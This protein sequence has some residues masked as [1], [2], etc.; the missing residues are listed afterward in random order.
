MSDS[1]QV[2]IAPLLLPVLQHCTIP[3]IAGSRVFI[4]ED[5][6]V[7]N[8]VAPVNTV[9][10]IMCSNLYGISVTDTVCTTGGHWVPTPK[11]CYTA[12]AHHA[13][14]RPVYETAD[15][16]VEQPQQQQHQ[17][18]VAHDD[19]GDQQGF[20]VTDEEFIEATTTTTPKSRKVC[21]AMVLFCGHPAKISY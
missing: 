17:H 12:S 5:E 16:V 20:Y 13:A 3:F 10:T 7:I 4:G 14:S 21:F 18:A 19:M 8:D 6:A 15:R 1:A 11:L 9:I 2:P